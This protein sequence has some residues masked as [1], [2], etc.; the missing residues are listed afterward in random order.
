MIEAPPIR[1]AD[2]DGVSIAYQVF[3]EGGDDLVYVPGGL[4]HLDLAWQDR[5]YQRMMQ[6][7]AGFARVT[8]FD[9]RGMGA[10]DP[11]PR[12][13]TLEERMRDIAAVM[14]AVGIEQAALFGNS[15]GA[16]SAALFAATFPQRTRA[17]VLCGAWPGGSDIIDPDPDFPTDMMREFWD[18]TVPL[19]L[20]RFGQGV[21]IR[22]FAPSLAGNEQAVAAMAA[23][24]RM[25]T[26]PAMFRALLDSIRGL[27]LRPILGS[28]SAP[29]LVL[30]RRD[31]S[32][33][34]EG[35]RYIASRIPGAKLVELEGDDHLPWLGDM[36]ALL[37][38]VQEFL[39]GARP[40][41]AERRLATVVF[42][43]IV[44]STEHAASLG[45]RRW[46]ALLDDHHDT[47]RAL[48][49]RF[50]GRLVKTIGDGTLALFDGPGSAVECARQAVRDAPR[51]GIELRAGVHAGECELMN[52]DVGGIAVHVGARIA[53]L[54]DSGEVLVS[55]TV[56]ELVAGSDLAFADRGVHELKGVPA[57]WQ[58]YRLA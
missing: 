27:D 49:E 11:V 36:D 44:G 17:L 48:T 58:V 20:E 15:E 38:E 28:I 7:L 18:K 21:T 42:T 43:D 56:K 54:A 50:D 1:Y 2:C 31:E 55:S 12:P 26:T 34:I 35:A 51:I 47:M 53:S 57:Q 5:R 4:S 46:R 6:R 40:K 41:R 37:D 39:T 8:V 16:S 13:P 29:T 19:W 52:G 14:D 33:P 3:G 25:A 22:I 10:S 23:F 32:P 24:E 30:H 9:K 45:D